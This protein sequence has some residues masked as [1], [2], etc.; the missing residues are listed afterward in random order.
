MVERGV[1]LHNLRQGPANAGHG[2]PNRLVNEEE[3]SFFR[4]LTRNRDLERKLDRHHITG[5]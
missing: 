4:D 1:E 2:D 3:R 5:K